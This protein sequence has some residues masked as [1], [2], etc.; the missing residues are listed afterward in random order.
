MKVD[1]GVARRIE[2]IEFKTRFVDNPDPLNKYE[3]PKDDS[4]EEKLKFMYEPYLSMLIEKFKDYKKNKLR[5]PKEVLSFT[6]DY[7][8][9]ND[10]Y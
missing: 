6:E 8:N 4:L 5:P 2:L 3:K 1:G 10:A 7:I 9:S